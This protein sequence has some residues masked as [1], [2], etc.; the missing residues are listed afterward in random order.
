MRI[1]FV[2]ANG[3]RSHLYPLLPLAKALQLRGHDVAVATYPSLCQA[4]VDA[5]LSTFT[6]P[7]PKLRSPNG[8]GAKRHG[9]AGV[10]HARDVVRGYLHDAVAATPELR[11]IVRDWKPHAL[12]RE[13]AAW[14]AWLVGH[15]EAVP[16]ATFDYAPTPPLLMRTLLGDLFQS[17]RSDVGLPPEPD[18]RSIYGLAHLLVGP[19]GWF[20]P[21]ALS[22]ASHV[23]RPSVPGP[24][25]T[26]E[27][28]IVG[29]E[30]GPSIYVTLGTM[31][32]RTP[33]ILQDIIRAVGGQSF[34]A[35]VNMGPDTEAALPHVPKNVRL[36]TF[37]PQAVEHEILSR[38]DAVVCH[39]G[40]GSLLGAM[41]HG[42]PS[43]CVPLGNGDD[44]M[45]IAGL[46]RLNAGIVWRPS[47]GGSPSFQQ[48]VG[49]LLSD[50]AYRQGAQLAASSLEGL[51]TFEAAAPLVE[52]MVATGQP[53]RNPDWR[54]ARSWRGS[55]SRAETTR[56]GRSPGR[57]GEPY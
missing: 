53:V 39:G 22:E 37:M 10:D 43:L 24:T 20:H 29:L 19:P 28:W 46:E 14:A 18:L 25:A 54:G 27:P 5:G 56:V 9:V 15:L 12:V 40:Y 13:P 34:E 7:T 49:L 4:A 32:H 50:P 38:V 3:G 51:P 35:V 16:V 1:L 30:A 55:N 57:S 52:Q 36:T 26:L 23:F 8:Q 21:D 31:F 44:S 47:G 6:I 41:M 33:G 17:A 42:R 48:A 45:R 2:V 11:T